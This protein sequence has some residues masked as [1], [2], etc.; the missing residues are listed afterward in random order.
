MN[1]HLQNSC[2]I[3]THIPTKSYINLFIGLTSRNRT[4]DPQLR[5]LLLYPSE[6]WSVLGL[7]FIAFIIGCNILLTP[8]RINSS[9]TAS[10]S[11][12]F[13]IFFL[14]FCSKS[15]KGVGS[16]ISVGIRT[17]RILMRWLN[18]Q[19]CYRPNHNRVLTLCQRADE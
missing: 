11:A 3:L 13:A 8:T 10:W 9:I 14:A 1:A 7:S 15:S 4:Y 17:R 18:R 16:S 2:F 19:L 12:P 5:R 6:L